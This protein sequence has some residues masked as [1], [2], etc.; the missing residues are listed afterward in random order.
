LKCR[1]SGFGEVG[2]R[3]RMKYGLGHCDGLERISSLR[4]R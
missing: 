4:F 2:E 3:G 1:D